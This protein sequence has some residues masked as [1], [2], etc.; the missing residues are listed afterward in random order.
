[1]VREM[2]QSQKEQF[3][4]SLAPSCSPPSQQDPHEM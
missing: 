1:M 3:P 4:R 2:T